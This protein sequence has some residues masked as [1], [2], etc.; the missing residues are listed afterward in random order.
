[1]RSPEDRPGP[2]RLTRPLEVERRRARRPPARVPNPFGASPPFRRGCHPPLVSGRESRPGRLEPS[3]S[4]ATTNRNR[5]CRPLG[6][7]QATT[8]ILRSSRSIP[9]D[10]RPPVGLRPRPGGGHASRDRTH[11]RARDWQR[12]V[13]GKVLQSPQI[14]EDPDAGAGLITATAVGA[15]AGE[16][17]ARSTIERGGRLKHSGTHPLA[18]VAQGQRAFSRKC[19]QYHMCTSV[20]TIHEGSPLVRLTAPTLVR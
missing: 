9:R 14:P 7:G 18:S 19:G 2:A 20:C 16:P 8:E 3:A 12:Y 13:V 10:D 5:S 15:R 4:N 17:A 1:M 6:E 11:Q